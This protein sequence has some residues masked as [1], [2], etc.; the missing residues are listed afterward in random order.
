[1]IMSL[2]SSIRAHID[3]APTVPTLEKL[4]DYTAC[5]LADRLQATFA[6]SCIAHGAH[7]S[8][9][10]RAYGT[11]AFAIPSMGHMH[12]GRGTTA[13]CQVPQLHL[14]ELSWQDSNSLII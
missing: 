13:H 5:Q 12:A 3:A 6:A 7:A 14:F 10:C 4:T 8:Y 2:L 9:A 1:M 11:G